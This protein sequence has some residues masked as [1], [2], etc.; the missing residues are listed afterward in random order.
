[1]KYMKY[2]SSGIKIVDHE[3]S[4]SRTTKLSKIESCT[5]RILNSVR[6]FWH[7]C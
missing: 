4:K 5:A 6:L 1:M 3:R 7:I 2:R